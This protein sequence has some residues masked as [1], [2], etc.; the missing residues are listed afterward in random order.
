MWAREH[1][2]IFVIKEGPD[3]NTSQVPKDYCTYRATQQNLSKRMKQELQRPHM[4][5]NID[6]R[7]LVRQVI[8]QTNGKTIASTNHLDMKYSISGLPHYSKCPDS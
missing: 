5:N 2:Q 4:R 7:E 6:Y 3:V 1:A 8:K